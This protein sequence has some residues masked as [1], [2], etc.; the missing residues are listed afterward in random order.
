MRWACFTHMI[1]LWLLLFVT[2]AV[3]F[4]LLYPISI[5]PLLRF[6]PSY[7]RRDFLRRTFAF[8]WICW[9]KLR[10]WNSTRTIKTR[11]W[12]TEML[13]MIYVYVYL[14]NDVL[15]HVK[16]KE[17]FFR[18]SLTYICKYVCLMCRMPCES[19]RPNRKKHQVDSVS[20]FLW[21]DL[22]CSCDIIAQ[23]WTDSMTFFPE[24]FCR[25]LV[26]LAHSLTHIFCLS[27]STVFFSGFISCWLF[28]IAI[29]IQ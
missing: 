24:L 13:Y 12:N 21:S 25:C 6:I 18:L 27:T 1:S 9:F 15:W 14:L 22:L 2:C 16:Q 29:I 5:F 26:S 28:G 7:V 20:V 4:S 11:A 19:W 3:F 17:V 10:R 8:D 23:A